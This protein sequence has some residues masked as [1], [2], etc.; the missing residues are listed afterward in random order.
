MVRAAA[1]TEKAN[2][3]APLV[4][5]WKFHGEGD[6]MLSHGRQYAVQ[7][8]MQSRAGFYLGAAQLT[9]PHVQQIVYYFAAIS[10]A[11]FSRLLAD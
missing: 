11:L 2:R 8:I 6:G 1:V 4:N 7:Y 10:F 5:S 9:F 3:V